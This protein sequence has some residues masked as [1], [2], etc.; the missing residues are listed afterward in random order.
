MK[1]GVEIKGLKCDNPCCDFVNK[2]IPFEQYE[3]F[4][5]YPC[6]KCGQSLLTPQAYK[7]CVQMKKMADFIT[8]VTGGSK[9]NDPEVIIPLDMDKEKFV[10]Q[11][12]LEK[13][14][15]LNNFDDEEL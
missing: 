13:S 4:I 14:I 12:R 8:K 11:D 15:E 10:D 7:M 2:D 1:A 9:E 6:P 3:Q 5:D